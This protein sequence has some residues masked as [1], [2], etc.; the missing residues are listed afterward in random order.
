VAR[1]I[2]F[3]FHYERDAWRAG[4]VRN[5][6]M[7]P[8]EDQIGFIDAVDWESIKRQGEEAIKRWIAKQLDGTSAT[9]VLAGAETA[10]RRWI[11]HEIFESWNRGNG[12]FGVWI[13]NVKDVNKNIDVRGANPFDS[14][15]LPN[16]TLLS[17]VCK[18][19][20]WVHDQGRDQ[21]GAWAEEAAR[22]RSSFGTD[23]KIELIGRVE[24]NG[25]G[26]GTAALAAGAVA[27]GGLVAAALRDKPQPPAP[28]RSSPF[29]PRSP[30]CA[31]RDFE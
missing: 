24:K 12:V 25:S 11:Q 5:C 14:F 26:L 7:L 2:F 4:Q 3:S 16:G 15:K 18:I 8:S 17:A 20:D 28:A 6:N 1:K 21:L 29:T 22:I 23:Q 13:H 30:W 9:S 27:L 19:Y 31:N 10:G